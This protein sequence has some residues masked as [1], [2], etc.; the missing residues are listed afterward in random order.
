MNTKLLVQGIVGYSFKYSANTRVTNYS[1][2]VHIT[3]LAKMLSV[4]N[5]ACRCRRTPYI[6]CLGQ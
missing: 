3:I 1:L 6:R 4:D 5:I 2:I